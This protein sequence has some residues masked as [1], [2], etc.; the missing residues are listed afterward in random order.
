MKEW[1]Q[2][3]ALREKQILAL[4]GF[5]VALFVLYE[6]IWSPFTNKIDNMRASVADNQKLLAWMQNADEIMQSLT[7]SAKT[8]SQQTGSLLGLMQSE[9]NKSP[10][11]R[12][13][14][15]LRQSENDSVQMNLQKVNFDQMISFI[16]DLSNRYGLVTSQI[17][18]TPT[19][20]PGEVMADVIIKNS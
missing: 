1:W 20:T 4:G 3:L 16:T 6:I 11:G 14:T 8:K 10:L 5:V 15:Q 7:K 9:I 2:N 17:T 12:H 19:Q 18:V 13:V